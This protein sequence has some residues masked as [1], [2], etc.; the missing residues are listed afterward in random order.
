M[1]IFIWFKLW[2][3]LDFCVLFFNSILIILLENLTPDLLRLILLWSKLY[4]SWY[5]HWFRKVILYYSSCHNIF[6]AF[7]HLYQLII[8][9]L[10][11][12]RSIPNRLT[13]F[14][15]CFLKTQNCLLKSTDKMTGCLAGCLLIEWTESMLFLAPTYNTN[16]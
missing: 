1:E 16:G 10:R 8:Y 9:L 5:L 12:L 15:V 7:I 4:I 13:D 11:Q 14:Q 2:W 3:C 6:I